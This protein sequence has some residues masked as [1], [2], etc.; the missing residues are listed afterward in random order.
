MSQMLLLFCTEGMSWKNNSQCYKS[1]QSIEFWDLKWLLRGEFSL[2]YGFC[3]FAPFLPF[4]P[5]F[6]LTFESLC[7]VQRNI[8]SKTFILFP[9]G[10]RDH[11]CQDDHNSVF[12]FRLPNS[13][14]FRSGFNPVPVLTFISQP[15]GSVYS[16]FILTPL[17]RI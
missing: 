10:N 17:H 7:S 8:G 6:P 4:C 3:S 12:H 11:F 14:F 5:W 9:S 15:P 13:C 1:L 2:H 16:C